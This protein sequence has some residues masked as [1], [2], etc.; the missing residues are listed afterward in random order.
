MQINPNGKGGAGLE[1]AG[2]KF[3]WGR[4]TYLMGI[5]NVTPDSFSGD[6][7]GN[8]VELSLAQARAFVAAGADMLDIGG[9]STNPYHSEPITVSEEL[10][11]VLPVIKAIK[12][13]LDVPLSIDTRKPVVARAALAEGAHIIND[14]TGLEDLAMRQVAAETQAPVIIM[15]MRGTPQTMMSM[16]DYGGQLIAELQ[17]FFYTRIQ[18]ILAVGVQ[19]HNIILDPGIG[20]AKNAPQN[21]EIVQRVLEIRAL[22]YP[23]LIGVSRKGFIGRLVAGGYDYEPVPPEQRIFGTAAAVALSIANGADIIRVHD[24]EAMSD[25]IKVTDAIVRNK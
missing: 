14:I 3:E 20:F 16:T 21:I 17:R 6:S 22:G 2:R 18:E 15:H 25:V 5:L 11:R 19:P 12:A 4:R 13:E 23:I 9:E 7:L 24:V 8:D 1:V 10:N